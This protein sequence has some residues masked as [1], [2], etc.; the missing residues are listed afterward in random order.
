MELWHLAAFEI[1][2]CAKYTELIKFYFRYIITFTQSQPRI[3]QSKFEN[4]C[5]NIILFLRVSI[6]SGG[7]RRE[8]FDCLRRFSVQASLSESRL[9]GEGEQT[10]YFR[11][12]LCAVFSSDLMRF[13]ID[14]FASF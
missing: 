12:S 2:F 6:E 3:K 4:K 7:L 13:A 11:L 8:K 1:C 10:C 9:S 5:I 14:F